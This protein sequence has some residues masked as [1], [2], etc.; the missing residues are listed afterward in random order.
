[1]TRAGVKDFAWSEAHGVSWLEAALP[2]ARVAFSTRCGGAS[3]P[4]YDTLNLGILTEDDPARVAANRRSLAEALGRDPDRVVFGVQVHGS[5]VQVHEH[6]LA[7]AEPARADAQVTAREDL[8]PLVLVADCLPLALS[9]PGAVAMAHC[10]W[11]GIVSGVIANT[12]DA[13]V[14]QAG[15][16]PADVHAALGPGIRACCYV[17]GPEVRSAFEQRGQ[18]QAL[19]ADGRLDLAVAV[20]GEL[21]RCG[22]EAERFA[23]CGLCTSCDEQRFFSHRR[24]G[25]R[26]GR[27]AG[28]VWRSS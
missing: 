20:R 24:D 15:C 16:E 6:R 26:T 23:D 17:V 11:R 14:Q 19:Q 5:G 25:G 28:L 9:A 13:L 3:A 10:G 22:V 12:V 8:T 7:G 18:V 27:Q 4:P 2:G 21:E 1:V